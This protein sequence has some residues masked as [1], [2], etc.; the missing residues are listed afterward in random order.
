MSS[1]T[2]SQK[3]RFLHEAASLYYKEGKT[4]AEVAEL[5]GVSRTKVI[6]AL[7]EARAAG[8]VQITIVDPSETNHSLARQLENTL[9][10][11]KA[12]VTTGRS[13]D[14]NFTRQRVGHAAAN[15]LM[16]TLENGVKLGL[17]WGRTLYDVTQALEFDRPYHTQ[18]V[19]LLGGLG[20]IA[21]SFQVHDMAR[22]AAERLGGTWRAFYVPALVD[23]PEAYESLMASADVNHV[24][25]AWREL[26]VA[27]VGLGNL[28]LGQDVRMLFADYLDAGAIEQL[29]SS[30]AVGDICMR[31]FDGDGTPVKG[32]HEHLFSISLQEFKAVPHKIAVACG[33]RKA[34]SILGAARGGYVNTLI[35]D[36]EAAEEVLHLAEK[37]GNRSNK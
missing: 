9:G 27:L 5:L 37:P 26:D 36:S 18:V 7:Q 11:G 3:E 14:A 15:Y 23:S 24:T 29:E 30:G 22:V 25:A 32:A 10:L 34:E 33:T 1:G 13:T 20:K 35:T 16:E 28:D 8:I 6:R 2:S 12:V 31:F 19:P 4:Q 17:G 21:P